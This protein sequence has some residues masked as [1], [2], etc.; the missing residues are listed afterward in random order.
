MQCQA[1][2]G[3]SHPHCAL[4]LAMA[5]LTLVGSSTRAT[6]AR[7]CS[8]WARACTLMVVGNWIVPWAV[9]ICFLCLVPRSKQ[10]CGHILHKQILGLLQASCKSHWFS[11]QL[12]G[13]IFPLSGFR[14]WMSNMWLEV[15][16]SQGG[17]LPV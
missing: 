11:N 5:A 2:A 15:L 12:R 16:T 3:S 9:S 7:R 14:A 4:S 1:Q 13:L 10:A 6:V 8:S 17:S